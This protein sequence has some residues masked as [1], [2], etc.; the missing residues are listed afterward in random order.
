MFKNYEEIKQ[1]ILKGDFLEGSFVDDMAAPV[2]LE[3]ES[4]YEMMKSVLERRFLIN[5]TDEELDARASEYGIFRKSG[6][7]ATGTIQVEGV[8]GAVI[9]KGSLFSTNT[10]LL[11]ESLEDRVIEALKASISVKALE[12]GSLY[13]VSALAINAMPIVISGIT[14]YSNLA[15]ITGGSN[16][17]SDEA[18][19]ERILLRIQSPSTSGNKAHYRQWALEVAGIADAKVIPQMNGAG[20]VGIIPVTVDRRKPSQDM[21][22]L[23]FAYVEEN[24]PIG[25]TPVVVAPTEKAINVGARVDIVA[26]YDINLI[27]QKYVE[28]IEEY[29][30]KS[31]FRLSVVDYFKCL[32]FFYD[33]EGVSTVIEFTINGTNT[34]VLI[35]ETEIQV[36]GTVEVGV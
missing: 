26:G 16:V 5:E 35:G 15:A 27:K 19:L 10:G 13:N 11:Y 1:G 7:H 28:L 23:V 31:V 14:S 8:E 36:L 34:N 18:L 24:R 9:P 30:I 21:I 29:L 4:V 32:S 12:V 25:A 17:E 6:S 22:D 33:I 3:I 2:S 20:T